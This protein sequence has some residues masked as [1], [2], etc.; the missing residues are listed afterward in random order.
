MLNFLNNIFNNSSISTFFSGI[1]T[2][3]IQGIT[4]KFHK[5]KSTN[6]ENNITQ[7]SVD[8][9]LSPIQKDIQSIQNSIK[10]DLSFKQEEIYFRYFNK[11]KNKFTDSD[12]N[13]LNEQSS[14]F[15]PKYNILLSKLLGLIESI[16][17]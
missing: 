14:A 9:K 11:Y 1:G 8:P 17:E 5:H 2:T 6:V 15:S 16:E 10:Y 3:L 13:I 7:Q 12:I 4:S